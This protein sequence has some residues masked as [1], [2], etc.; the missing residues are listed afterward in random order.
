L[1]I[2][3]PD[4]IRLLTRLVFCD[5][6]TSLLSQRPA[7]HRRALQG[8]DLAN[9]VRLAVDR[10]IDVHGLAEQSGIADYA[11]LAV[12]L[13]PKFDRDVRVAAILAAP[14]ERAEARLARVFL[15]LEDADWQRLRRAGCAA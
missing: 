13:G 12:E 1:L 5:L 8:M 10:A 7:E 4:Q 6:L 2:I 9:A 14:A 3:R 15:E 11:G